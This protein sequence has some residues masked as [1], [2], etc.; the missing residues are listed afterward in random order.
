MTPTMDREETGALPNPLGIAGIE[1]VEY[2]TARPQA[3]GQVLQMLGFVPGARHRS[4]EVTLYRQGGMNVIVNAH[5][6]AANVP[7]AEAPEVPRIAALAFRVRGVGASRIYFVD[8]WQEFSIYDVDFVKIP[9]VDARPQPLAGLRW[10][11]VVQYV[12]NERSEDWIEFYRELLGFEPIRPEQAFGILPKGRVLASPCGSFYLQLVEPEPGILDVEDDE[13]M[14]RVAFGTPDVLAAVSLLGAR[15]VE[16]HESP[17]LRTDARGGFPAD[18]AQRARPDGPRRW[19]R[20]RRGRGAR[21]RPARH[22][23]SG[24]ARLRGAD[25]AS[26]RLQ[27]RRRQID[28]RALR[29]PGREGAA[30]VLVDLGARQ[31]RHR[32][33]GAR[34]AQARDAGGAA[35]R[36]DRVRG[37]ELGPPRQPVPAGVGGAEGGGDA[38]RNQDR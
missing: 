32:T 31:R 38:P 16:F 23:L 5:G 30:G 26:A 34:P 29:A 25:R 19:S 3:F 21:Q 6:P 2:A 22:R 14:V 13:Q 33:E 35:G 18:H 15:G 4:R 10:F 12:G 27:G 9:T 37:A 8:R 17:Q 24:A 7:D 28:A 11:G 20:R 36:E 1:F